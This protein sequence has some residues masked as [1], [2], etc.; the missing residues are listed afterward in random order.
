MNTTPLYSERLLSLLVHI[1]ASLEEDLSLESIATQA[2]MSPFHFHRIFREAVG[3][4]LK[5][6]T[7]RLRLER[8]A[9]ELRIRNASV[10][11]V[12]LGAGYQSHETFTRAFRRQFGMTP[13][14]FRQNG[15]LPHPPT[16]PHNNL[17]QYT[18]TYQLSKV[19]VQKLNGIPV[20]FMRHVGPYVAVDARLFDQLQAWAKR[21]QLDTGENLLIGLGHDA[22]DVTPPDKLRYDACL[23]VPRPFHG[24]GN[25]GYQVTPAGY[26][27]IATYI[28]PY[29]PTMEQAYGEIFQEA[30]QL[31]QYEIVGLP[32]MEI[33]RTTRITP[34][35]A[36]NQTDV[37]IPVLKKS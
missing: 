2:D 19:R 9:H 35:Y 34:E 15:R 13:T 3:E 1:Q 17:N 8:A 7:Q 31:P 27:A 4:T 18:Q 36:L 11:A 12:A 24:E 32:L 22:P 20:A 10:L 33:Y 16:T 21:Q 23:Q 29:G 5:Q 26:F 6:Y 37:C 25:I 28:G 14:A 30:L